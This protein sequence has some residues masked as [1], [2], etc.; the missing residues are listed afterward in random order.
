[1]DFDAFW[2]MCDFKYSCLVD[3]L[4]K[5]HP[6]TEA[7]LADLKLT[8]ASVRN[9]MYLQDYIRLRCLTMLSIYH[10]HLR[11]VLLQTAQIDIGEI[12][13]YSDESRQQ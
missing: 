9:D 2:H 10:E 5:N 4:V 13:S 7:A 3:D 6:M 8:N 12:F 11:S 1:M